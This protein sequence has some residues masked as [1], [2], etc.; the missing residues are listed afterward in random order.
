MR[1]MFTK[2]IGDEIARNDEFVLRLLKEL[3]NQKI[4]KQMYK[5]KKGAN[6]IRRKQWTLTN[7]AYNAYKNLL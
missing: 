4:V 7:K 5:T 2:Q 3:E 6:F 1:G